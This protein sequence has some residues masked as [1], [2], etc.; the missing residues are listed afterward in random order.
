MRQEYDRV[1]GALDH[2][3][4]VARLN[5]YFPMAQYFIGNVYSDWGSVWM[6]RWQQNGGKKDDPA[7]AS[8]VSAWDQAEDAYSKLKAFA[9]N[10]VQT[11]HQMGTL[12]LKRMQ[13]ENVLGNAPAAK[14][15]GDAALRNFGLY[16][17]LDPVFPQN[18]YRI[19]HIHAIRDDLDAAEKAYRGALFY[20]SANVV[21]RINHDR[22]LETNDLL[23]RLLLTRLEKSKGPYAL[24]N[25]VFA[26]A[27]E[28]FT[29]GLHSYDL[30]DQPDNLRSFALNAHKGLGLLAL[31]AG[32]RASASVHWGWVSSVAPDDPDLKTVTGRR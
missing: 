17:L 29:S 18:F 5:P 16:Q 11:H 24:S 10:Y 32:D 6:S 30:M 13:L 15:R 8:A 20:N 9:P 4:E 22:N 31:R 21:N 12:E 7:L 14:E 19:A 2:Y 3:R 23:G 27:V 28:A 26:R 1:G 25:P